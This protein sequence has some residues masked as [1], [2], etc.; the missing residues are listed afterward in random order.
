MD[1]MKIFFYLR[2]GRVHAAWANQFPHDRKTIFTDR[3][4]AKRC[5]TWMPEHMH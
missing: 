4:T 5:L 1:G 3:H 2:D